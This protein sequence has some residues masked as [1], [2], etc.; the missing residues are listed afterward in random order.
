[1]KR[2]IKAAE[3][4]PRKGWENDLI[5]RIDEY[6]YHDGYEVTGQGEGV[7]GL[8]LSVKYTG[9]RP[10]RMPIIKLTVM[11]DENGRDVYVE[12]KLIFPTLQNEPQDYYDSISYW[13][14]KW[15]NVGGA[16]SA[17]N[18]YSLDIYEEYDE[19]D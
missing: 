6:L 7:D 2:A 5:E 19:E 14:D 18:K 9:K 8:K 12:P 16:I 11:M 3:N 17:I 13:I 4:N 1:M 15:A 10:D